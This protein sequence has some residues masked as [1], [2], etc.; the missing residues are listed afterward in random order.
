MRIDVI[1]TLTDFAK[2]EDNWNAVYDAD[3][4][5]QLFISWKWL[6]GWLRQITSP[7][8]VLAA[9]ADGRAE[10]PY[11]AFLPMRVQTKTENGHI[12]NELNMAGNFAADYTGFLCA[13][14]LEHLVVP[15]FIRHIKQLNWAR[16][17]FE[18]FRISE[19]RMRLFL[20]H[21]P[22][23]G[24]QTSEPSRVGK[25]DG[26]DNSL[27]PFS[28]LPPN[29]DS[30]LETLS[31]NTR[32]KIRRLL[33]LVDADGEYR[34]T[35]AT[36]ETLERDLNTLLQFWET[37]WKPRKGDLVHTLVRSNRAMLTRSFN[38]GLV[39]LP[40][41]WKEDRP[42]AALATLVDARKHSFLFYITGRDETF[43]GPPPGMILHAHSI[44]H[45]IANGITEYDFL[46]GNETYKYSFGVKE[47]R[48][49]STVV[50]TKNGL[51]LGGRIDPRTVPDVLEEATKFHQ[52][53][54]LP[55]AEQGY[56]DVLQVQPKNAD[57]IHRLGQLFT[58]K[59]DHVAAKRFYKTLTT[60]RPD[61][62]KSWLCLAQSCDALE[63]HLD[64]AD[65][66]REV[67]RL[68]P[69]LPDVFSSLAA[70]LIRLGRIAEVNTALVTALGRRERAVKKNGA[71]AQAR[72]VA[73][74]ALQESEP[75]S[76]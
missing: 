63:Q 50:A 75:A 18:N 15:A 62:Y 10:G 6:S 37:K 71:V 65:A 21:F 14:G 38:A 24:F 46:R 11:V 34:I 40:T 25:V 67:L 28:V 74:H 45:A 12:H 22:K 41:L 16:L 47:R 53:G 31:T 5:A 35:V 23:A 1:D 33:R 70:S 58:G 44:R 3:P 73:A 48:I 51:N 13:P 54:K 20:A 8:F 76:M 68:K 56:R 29:W 19:P 4:D 57:A 64:A 59:G 39:Y 17:N 26:I 61:A 55:E 32:Q 9:R 72:H 43:D 60:I 2:L 52:S 69:D 7:W 30:Y 49:R 27:C 42:L 66:Y 36:P